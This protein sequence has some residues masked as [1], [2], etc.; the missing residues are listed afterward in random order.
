MQGMSIP[1]TPLANGT[2]VSGQPLANWLASMMDMNG[3]HRLDANERL[4][5]SLMENNLPAGTFE[6]IFGPYFTNGMEETSLSQLGDIPPLG[7]IFSA[8]VK[9]LTL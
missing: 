5:A 2:V 6:K 9:A 7:Q 8:L 3:N 4:I 1:N